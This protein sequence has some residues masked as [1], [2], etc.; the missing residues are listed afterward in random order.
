MEIKRQDKLQKREKLIHGWGVN[1]LDYKVRLRDNFINEQGVIVKKDIWFCPA[2]LNWSGMIGRCGRHKNYLDASVDSGWK[3]ASE[4]KIWF[5]K[6]YVEGWQLDKDILISGNRVYSAS[7]CAFVPAYLNSVLLLSN[8]TR[9]EYPLGVSFYKFKHYKR[10]KPFIAQCR[11]ESLGTT[12]KDYF[13]TAREA[14]LAWQKAK[15]LSF[16][17]ALNRY[18]KEPV[19]FRT[20]VAEAINLRIWNLHLDVLNGKETTSF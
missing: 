19:G 16:E 4:F 7:T 17:S 8:A 2:Y 20:D 3:H 10:S 5:D 6:N 11:N 14:H 15:I 9:G 13:H 18:A 12:Y 1:D